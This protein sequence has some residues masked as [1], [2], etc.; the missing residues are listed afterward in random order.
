[1]SVESVKESFWCVVY[2]EKPQSAL[3]PFVLLQNLDYFNRK[4]SETVFI[5]YKNLRPVKSYS[6]QSCLTDKE[7]SCL[8]DKE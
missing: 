1:M 2:T 4:Y 7:Q 6:S 3:L 5:C 8:T